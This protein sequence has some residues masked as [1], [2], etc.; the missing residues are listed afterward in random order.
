MWERCDTTLAVRRTPEPV[1]SAS[2]AHAVIFHGP[3]D[4]KSKI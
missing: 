4:A 2:T 1:G 3:N